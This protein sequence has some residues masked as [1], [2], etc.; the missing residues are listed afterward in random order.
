MNA[1]ASERVVVLGGTGFIGSRLVPALRASGR[2]VRVASRNPRPTED[3][4]VEFVRCDLETG[5]G[6]DHA[7]DGADLAYFLVHGMAEGPGFAARERMATENFA[8]AVSRQR[9]ARVIYLG[10]LYP[11]GELSAHLASRRQVGLTL[12]QETGA[13]AVRA[14]VVV[15]FGGASFEILYALSQRLPLM[16]APR[17]LASLCQ[18]VSIDDT[19]RGLAAAAG[20]AGA[21]EVDLVGPDVLTYREMLEVTAT[22][23]RGR[24]PVM[25]PVPLLSPE[26]SAHW[27]RLVARVDMNVARSLVAS[28]RH[29]LVAERPLLMQELGLKPLGFRES[30]RAALAQR[31]LGSQ[32]G[33]V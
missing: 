15:G 10:G 25:F 2:S 7:L 22:E 13:L 24:K 28:L 20:I 17:W 18:P 4:S 6:V 33:T 23:L 27:L 12:I 31:R 29:D 14:G 26:L 9:V 8:R 21:R 30:V 19:V 3:P 11:K 5:E 1:A 32:P 16:I